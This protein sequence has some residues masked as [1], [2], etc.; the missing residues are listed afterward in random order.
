[1]RNTKP[2]GARKLLVENGLHSGPLPTAIESKYAQGRIRSAT[3][4]TPTL[5]SG[6]RAFVRVIPVPNLGGVRRGCMVPM[7]SQKRKGGFHEP[8]YVLVVVLVLVLDQT[9][10][11]RGGGG[12]ER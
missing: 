4:P 7:H 10:L 8:Y 9:A 2:T 5:P 6:E 12:A 11:F 3:N 1:M